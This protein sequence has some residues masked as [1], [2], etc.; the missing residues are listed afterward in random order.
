MSVLVNFGFAQEAEKE[1]KKF[2]KKPAKKERM[3]ISLT[4]DNLIQTSSY[5]EINPYNS[6]GV[7]IAMLYDLIIKKSQFSVALG[8][9]FNSVNIKS[10]AF[11]VNYLTSDGGS[12]TKMDTS[13]FSGAT[14][15]QTKISLNYIDIPF[16][17]R[18]RS[19]SQGK[20]RKRASI[21]LGFEVGFL[22]QSHTKTTT[23]KDFLQNRVNL[24]SKFKSYDIENLNPIKYGVTLRAGYANFYVIGY[25]G[26]SQVFK[27]G[28]GTPANV[29]SVGIGFS[30]F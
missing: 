19:K 9:G 24:G 30:P 8:G 23:E 22:V 29:L 25:Y 13:F 3:L 2:K 21:A 14:L 10:N 6:R 15:K 20:K 28:T 27:K 5:Y 4:A 26:L 17:V 18:W 7:D 16:E 11:P 12:F 1:P